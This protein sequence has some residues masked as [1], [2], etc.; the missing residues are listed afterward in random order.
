MNFIKLNNRFTFF[1]SVFWLFLMLFDIGFVQSHEIQSLVSNVYIGL[2][3]IFL[4]NITFRVQKSF[5]G[6]DKSKKYGQL[7]LGLLGFLIFIIQISNLLGY[8]ILGGEE[9]H[10]ILL[11]VFVIF[12]F[13]EELELCY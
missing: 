1:L 7:F 13:F 11:S 9:V 12:L 8:H 5:L 2:N 4:A 6:K 10:R 3:L